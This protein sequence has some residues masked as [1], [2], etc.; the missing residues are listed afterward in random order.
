MTTVPSP[1]DSPASSIRAA[2]RDAVFS[3][4]PILAG[5][6]FVATTIKVFRVAH[7]DISTTVAI[8]SS[9]N[10]VALLKGVIVTLLPGFLAGM[11]ALGIWLW[12][13]SIAEGEDAATEDAKTKARKDGAKRALYTARAGIVV[14][15]LAIGFF[16]IPTFAFASIFL[17]VLVLVVLL[18]IRAKNGKKT[19]LF[20]YTR[21]TLITLSAIVA[22]GSTLYLAISS[23][24]WL[25]MRD[26]RITPGSVIQVGNMELR[27]HV[28]AYILDTTKT[29][30]TLLLD[31]P[32]AVVTVDPSAILPNP[33]IC[34]PPPSALRS[35]LLRPS[36]FIGVEKD[37]GSPYPVC[38]PPS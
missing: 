7:M 38:P 35:I 32:R 1:T 22:V 13:N 24:V 25:P 20:H 14:A 28:A 23:D 5:L 31:N 9:A 18:I 6:T 16:T 33:A 19:D 27:Q 21:R 10:S 17:P 15:L 36:Q 2:V 34:I 26:V 3:G 29:D 8:V 4:L 30:V 37:Y 11:L 12:A